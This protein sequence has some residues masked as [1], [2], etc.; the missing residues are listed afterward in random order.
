MPGPSGVLG[1]SVR[2]ANSGVPGQP[3]RWSRW[4]TRSVDPDDGESL[5]GA[6][7]TQ[8]GGARRPA[9]SN[10]SSTPESS[11]TVPERVPGSKR[12]TVACMRA[13]LAEEVRWPARCCVGRAPGAARRTGRPRCRRHGAASADQGQRSPR[14][15]RPCAQPVTDGRSVAGS[16][17][18]V[19]AVSRVVPMPSTSHT[20]ALGK[21]GQRRPGHARAQPGAAPAGPRRGRRGGVPANDGRLPGRRGPRAALRPAS[22]RSV[23][24][25]APRAVRQL[26][27]RRLVGH[28]DQRS[29][30]DGA[31][32]AAATV[33]SAKARASS[34]RRA[35]ARRV[36]R[37]LATSRRLTGTTRHQAS[38]RG[39]QWTA[40]VRARTDPSHPFGSL[41]S[42]GPRRMT[43]PGRSRRVLRA[44]STALR[45]GDEDEHGSDVRGPTRRRVGGARGRRR[46][47]YGTRHGADRDARPQAAGLPAGCRPC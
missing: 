32:S 25:S 8:A 41:P 44:A 24:T 38:H 5:T 6:Q 33:S 40:R 9:A 7:Q 13:R 28:D 30:T 14:R 15:R 3:Q 42:V 2:V 18:R 36:S 19:R 21:V 11:S 45:D 35:P 31:A 4:L 12:R 1:N 17:A 29:D 43:R 16:L 26:G 23:M 34:P 10:G 37:V 39:E 27:G 20:S 22:G 46:R 47:R